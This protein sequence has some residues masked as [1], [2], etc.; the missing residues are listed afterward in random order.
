LANFSV[1]A[2]GEDFAPLEGEAQGEPDLPWWQHKESSYALFMLVSLASIL[3]AIYMLETIVLKSTLLGARLVAKVV[4]VQRKLEE[5]AKS[6][7]HKVRVSLRPD[8]PLFTTVDKVNGAASPPAV[9]SEWTCM[10]R[11]E[12]WSS[13]EKQAKTRRNPAEIK[14]RR[15]M[16]SKQPARR[17]WDIVAFRQ[18][19]FSARE[20]KGSV[21]IHMSRLGRCSEA[22]DVLVG[23]SE[24]PVSCFMA[25][26]GKDFVGMQTVVRFKPGQ[27]TASFEVKLL[28]TDT[29]STTRFFLVS[30]KRVVSDNALLGGPSI[31]VWGTDEDCGPTARVA[32][33]NDSVFPC[34]IPKHR[35]DDPSGLW[36]MVYYIKDRIKERGIHFWKTLF[37]RMYNPVHDVLVTVYVRKMLI[38]WACEPAA[39]GSHRTV[40]TVTLIQFASM[41][42]L[43]WGDQMQTMNR[44]RTGAVRMVHRR[45]LLQKLMMID[46]QETHEVPPT[47][48]VYNALLNVECATVLGYWQAYE[49]SSNSFALLLC[50]LAT[51]VDPLKGWKVSQ[52]MFL[53]SLGIVILVPISIALVMRRRETLAKLLEERMERETAWVETFSWV[54]R[55]ARNIFSLGPRERA[56][57]ESMFVDQ[58]DAFLDKHV[59]TRDLTNDSAWVTRWLGAIGYLSAMLWGAFRLLQARREDALDF[60]TGDYVLLL[61]VYLKFGSYLNAVNF[62]IVQMQTAAVSVRRLATLLNLQENRSLYKD[63]EEA[64]SG[65][66]VDDAP[67][68]AIE[69][70]DVLLAFPPNRPSGL[71]PMGPIDTPLN[72]TIPLGHLVKV[73]GGT[74]PQRMS[75]MAVVARILQP[76]AGMVLAPHHVWTVMMPAIPAELPKNCNVLETLASA[77][78]API[79]A[80]SFAQVLELDTTKNV[81]VL[82]P[83]EM[84]LLA[85]A[86]AM[87]RDPEVLVL[88][89]PFAFVATRLRNRLAQLLRV[90]QMGGAE[91]IVETL[92]RI[93][94]NSLKVSEER[95]R[96]R[97]R[98]LIIAGTGILGGSIPGESCN[99]V[100]INLDMLGMRSSPH[101]PLTKSYAGHEAWERA[102]EA[103]SDASPTYADSSTRDSTPTSPTQFGT[104]P[105]TF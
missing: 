15:R 62:G 101:L 86:R 39:G 99:D 54:C 92:C 65:D 44:G 24:A 32:I 97:A 6:V 30:L 3:G 14:M 83:G 29:W 64:E 85:I 84:Q 55:S 35:M 43:R 87:L 104:P 68:D 48:W 69:L 63:E 40:I 60:T 100:N 46:Y 11:E 102:W 16:M 42:L 58:T 5:T 12:F 56:H 88:I 81:E 91:C 36:L 20:T 22:V 27:S 89:R 28:R 80:H 8:S 47:V 38:D 34:N 10:Q 75:F 2:A 25:E 105:P 98:T 103:V 74:E 21:T 52:A 70:R 51:F 19:T 26:A 7:T 94:G 76:T 37:G 45:Q 13:M 93:S 67:E 95:V 18:Q 90:W 9:M 57:M 41:V 49:I 61:S 66:Q 23:T 53:P 96:P 79:V 33:L 59:I 31:A 72:L 1:E 50:L 71:G 73:R 78:T 77:G 4:Q 17:S 82:A